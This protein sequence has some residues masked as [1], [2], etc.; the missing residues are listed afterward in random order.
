[1][2]QFIQSDSLLLP[3]KYMNSVPSIYIIDFIMLI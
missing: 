1:V 3:Q 2:E